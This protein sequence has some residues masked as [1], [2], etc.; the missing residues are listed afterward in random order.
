MKQNCLIEKP[1]EHVTAEKRDAT[2]VMLTFSAPLPEKVTGVLSQREHAPVLGMPQST[3]ATRENALIEKHW[4]LS[5][6]KKGI[7]WALTQCKKRYSKIDE[8]LWLLLVAAFNNHP[9][10]IVSLNTKETLS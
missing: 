3:L 9:Y 4:Q 10:V 2:K 6:G 8:A 5:T 7:Y 1:G